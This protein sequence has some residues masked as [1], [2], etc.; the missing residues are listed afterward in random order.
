MKQFALKNNLCNVC[1]IHE[2]G[3]MQL[4]VAN[5]EPMHTAFHYRVD[6][7]LLQYMRLCEFNGINFEMYT[8]VISL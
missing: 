4:Y 6:V 5:C 8:D 3:W 7:Y 1:F 2:T